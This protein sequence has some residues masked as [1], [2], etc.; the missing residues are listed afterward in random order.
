[1]K[2]SFY[3]ACIVCAGILWGIISIFIRGLSQAGLTPIQVMAV[4]AII[5]A[6]MAAVIIGIKSPSLFRIKVQDVW[7]FIGTG[8]ISLTFF[9]ICYF[10]TIVSC[11]ASVAV[12]LLYTSPI[13]IILFSALLF[14]EKITFPKVIAI[15]MTTAGCIL[16]AG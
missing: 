9:S 6:P 7:M 12:V 3:A 14:H 15:V 10:K 1:M 5:S 11:G 4:R 16:V 8:V 13:F 2:K